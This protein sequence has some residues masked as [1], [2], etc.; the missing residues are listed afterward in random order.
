MVEKIKKF[1]KKIRCFFERIPSWSIINKIKKA[2]LLFTYNGLKAAIN[3]SKNTVK[4]KIN[5]VNEFYN[6]TISF[7]KNFPKNFDIFKK[8][9]RIFSQMWD[10]ALRHLARELTT[11]IVDV[12]ILLIIKKA[13]LSECA[14]FVRK[15]W[16]VLSTHFAKDTDDI[17]TFVHPITA[18]YITFL[19]WCSGTFMRALIF[20]VKYVAF[21]VIIF[22]FAL[23]CW[24]RPLFFSLLT[25]FLKEY[26]NCE[27]EEFYAEVKFHLKAMGFFFFLQIILLFFF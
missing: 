17:D 27:L 6:K 2:L 22:S 23:F 18:E 14:K 4:S 19:L 21:P 10:N 26:R 9:Y 13:S 3:D 24:D 16:K 25:K 8:N 11:L 12:F 7:Y 15:R 1:I 20:L 5:N